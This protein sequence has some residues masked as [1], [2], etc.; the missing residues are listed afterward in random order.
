MSDWKNELA[1]ERKHLK[2]SMA[3]TFCILLMIPVIAVLLLS[4]SGCAV[5]ASVATWDQHQNQTRGRIL[6]DR[7]YGTGQ[8]DRSLE[9]L[10]EEHAEW[11]E[12]NAAS[13]AR[14]D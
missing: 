8:D 3:V 7:R 10:R 1:T 12:M 13:H 2:S 9:Q 5:T 6:T 4:Q 14:N 11:K